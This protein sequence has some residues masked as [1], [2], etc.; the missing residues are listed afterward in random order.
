[1]V[2]DAVNGLWVSRLV[3]SAD[4]RAAAASRVMS[5]GIAFVSLGIAALA[6][7]RFLLPALD[8]GLAAWGVAPSLAVLAIVAAAYG[9]AMVARPAPVAR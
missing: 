9:A 7:A 8:E 6:A 4:A 1:V 5:L 3:R 2:T